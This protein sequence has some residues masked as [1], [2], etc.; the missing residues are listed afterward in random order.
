[1]QALRIL[2]NIKLL[3]RD[4]REEEA[5]EMIDAHL[6]VVAPHLREEIERVELETPQASL[7][8]SKVHFL[9]QNYDRAIEYAMGA[10]SLLVDDGSFYY[11]AL[12]HR[13][14]DAVGS[15]K[16]VRSFIIKLIRAEDV[17]DSLIGYLFSIRAYDLLKKVL[18]KHINGVEDCGELIELLVRLATEEDVLSDVYQLLVEINILKEPFIFYLV[19]ALFYFD[20]QDAIKGL[21]SELARK[22]ILLCYRV[23]FY[24]EDTYTSELEVED[25]RVMSLLSGEVKRRAL[26]SFLLEKNLTCFKFLESIAR[27]RTSYLAHINALMNLGTSNDTFYRSNTEIFS[28][29]KEWAKFSEVATLGMMHPRD[30]NPYEILKNYLPDETSQREGGALM[31]LG[32]MRAGTWCKEDTGYLLYFLEAESNFNLELVHGACLGLGLVNLGLGDAE[33]LE[34]LKTF[35]KLDQTLLIE[36]G[37]YGM[38][39]VGQGTCNYELMEEIAVLAKETEFER[40]KRA[41]GVAASLIV[42]FSEGAFYSDNEA[43]MGSSEPRSHIGRMLADKDAA[44]RCSGLLSLG[45]AYVGKGR[46]SIISVL[47]PYLNDGD[48]DVR[49]AAVIAIALV[50]CNDRDLLVG[51]LEPLSENHNFY[52]RAAVALCLGLLLAGTGDGV[53]CNILEALMYDSNGLVRQAACMGVGFLVM[54]CNPSL[55]PNYKRIMNKLNKMIVDKNEESS[56]ELGAVFGRGLSEAGGRNVVFGVRNLSGKI[57]GRMVTGAIMFLHYWYWYPFLNMVSL[58]ALPTA[59]FCFNE[60]LEEEEISIETPDEYHSLLVRL[61]DMK[62]TRRFRQKTAEEKEV[63]T[64]AENVLKSGSRCTLHQMRRCGIKAPGFFFVKKSK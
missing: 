48:D 21:L 52:V 50:C 49:R 27:T 14:M 8:L 22:D 42:M 61:P 13:M 38:G 11:R 43:K 51:T 23:A 4:K 54:Q 3:L 64:K 30:A 55:V 56:V 31:A 26:S 10:G 29:S 34:R 18:I 39:L 59:I 25:P 20:E 57:S 53:C 60:N 37:V 41:A 44:V 36:S 6:D 33:L 16:K 9:L 17:S 40:V 24:I 1:M 45:S 47:L 32:L 12:M 7:C 46:L 28:Q 2:P 62:K 63:V 58:C 15:N 5:I 19:D 35:S